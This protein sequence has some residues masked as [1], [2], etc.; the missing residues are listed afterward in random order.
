MRVGVEG[1]NVPHWG[2]LC[3]TRKLPCPK[4]DETLQHNAFQAWSNGTSGLRDAVNADVFYASN[5]VSDETENQTRVEL[6]D[7]PKIIN[8]LIPETL[9]VERKPFI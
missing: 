1:F 5:V 9:G 6:S 8:P 3:S 4:G 7:G 2:W